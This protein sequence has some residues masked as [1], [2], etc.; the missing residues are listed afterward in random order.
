VSLEQEGKICSI[1]PTRE[2][3]MKGI[4]KRER[5]LIIEGENLPDCISIYFNETLATEVI[6]IN[7]TTQR[8]TFLRK[9]IIPPL[10]TI[11]QDS[12]NNDRQFFQ[13][14]LNR[15]FY[16]HVLQSRDYP[17]VV[18][19]KQKNEHTGNDE[20]ILEHEQVFTYG[21]DEQYFTNLKK[22]VFK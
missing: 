4:E 1:T 17:V 22:W 6:D 7:Q 9:C 3:D 11:F 12:L 10:Q 13:M 21:V 16:F 14:R 20:N 18:F 2:T 5:F 15:Y 19:V 8:K